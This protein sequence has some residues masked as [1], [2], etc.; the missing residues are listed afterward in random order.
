[1]RYKLIALLLCIT[2][3]IISSLAYLLVYDIPQDRYHQHIEESDRAET[4]YERYDFST[5][6][7]LVH[8]DTDGV[9]IPGAGTDS[10]EYTV[11]NDGSDRI[12][13]SITIFDGYDYESNNGSQKQKLET[14]EYFSK[15]EIHVRGRSSRFFDKHG[16]ALRFVT[17]TGENNPMS[18]MGM[19]SHHEWVLHGPFLD[20]TL[21]R[22]YMWY[23]IAGEVMDY[24][25]N[26]RFC[27]VIIN[28]EYVGLYVMVENIT[29]G[30][31]KGRLNL[32]VDKKSASFSGYL[33]RLDTGSDTLVKNIEPFSAYTFRAKTDFDIVYPGKSNLTPE[34][35][36]AI[37]KDFSTFEKALYSY[38]FDNK[39][40]GYKK[41]IDVDN[42]VDYF[43]INE[44]TCNYDA[45]YLSTYIYRGMDDKFHMSIWDFNS[46]CDNYRETVCDPHIFA[47]QDNVWFFMLMK[48]EDFTD[49]VISRYRRLRAA[50]FADEYL[51][52]YIDE[53]VEFLGDAIGR[54]YEKW[55]YSFGQEY[56]LLIPTER[57]PR[58][59]EDS[60]E[61]M[62]SFLRER[63]AW[64]DLNIE[65]VKQYSA[66]SYVKK[67]NEVAN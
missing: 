33:L 38:D 5:H 15:I 7:P 64:M 42:F 30:S 39:K 59:F 52:K 60:I 37:T 10:G 23:N 46:A 17:D 11:A 66:R 55:G 22:N 54:N 67:F 63:T 56:D 51:E 8:I 47:M 27:E 1:M 40:F 18:V 2:V 9:E 50:F 13:A 45:G 35:N 32:T 12:S 3:I 28:D 65:S 34:L 44:L 62:K 31:T 41:L 29:A 57:N 21:I 43:L 53:T 49:R 14:Q 24:A 26:V 16:Y 20:K 48:D 58:T 25:P 4:F 19:D 36:R 6:L 61:S